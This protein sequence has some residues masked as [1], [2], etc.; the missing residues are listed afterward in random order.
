MIHS[1]WVL[2]STESDTPNVGAAPRPVKARL[3]T[4]AQAPLASSGSRRRRRPNAGHHATA[5]HRAARTRR[6]GPKAARLARGRSCAERLDG[7]EHSAMIAFVMAV[8]DNARG[9]ATARGSIP[10]L[11]H[12]SRRDRGWNRCRIG[13]RKPRR[14]RPSS[15]GSFDRRGGHH[16]GT[17]SHGVSDPRDGAGTVPAAREGVAHAM[18]SASLVISRPSRGGKLRRPNRSARFCAGLVNRL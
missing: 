5:K 3:A 6:P 1:R 10:H 2:G 13:G 8:T 18:V 12:N 11:P 16:N 9:P 15:P 17:D 14:A 4:L 7:A